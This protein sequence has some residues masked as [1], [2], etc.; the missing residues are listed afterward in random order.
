MIAETAEIN[1]YSFFTSY[2]S[3]LKESVFQGH[4][5]PVK[6]HTY[7]NDEELCTQHGKGI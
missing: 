1:I 2:A 6:M 4:E 3:I 5:D 7:I